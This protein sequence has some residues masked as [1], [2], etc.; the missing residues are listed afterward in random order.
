MYARP[1]LHDRLQW[2]LSTSPTCAY[3]SRLLLAAE[4]EWEPLMAR[5]GIRTGR[6]GLSQVGTV[7]AAE[8]ACG[9]QG[10]VASED[11]VQVAGMKSHS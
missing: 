11:P 4:E 2:L 3:G 1:Q 6:E 5:M 8:R 9:V 7:E 10:S